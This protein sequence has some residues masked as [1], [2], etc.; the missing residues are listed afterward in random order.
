MPE[1]MSAQGTIVSRQ[2]GCVGQFTPIAELKNVTPPAL[3]RKTIETTTH[4]EQDDAYVVGIRRHGD[5][6][7]SMNFVSSNA[8]Q[9]HLTGLQKSWYD[10]ALDAYKV[11]FP[12]GYS[13]VFSGYV[14]AIT[15]KAGV[16]A[17][18]EAD[19]TIRPTSAHAWEIPA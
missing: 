19:V 3:T 12:D 16:D 9:D 2:P 17:A 14:T 10:G 13:W 4:N 6:Q 8:T 1:G 18:L 11:T 5:L 15:P 7:L